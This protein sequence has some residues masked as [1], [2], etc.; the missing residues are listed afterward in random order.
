MPSNIETLSDTSDYPKSHSLFC[1]SLDTDIPSR[2]EAIVES[3]VD[4]PARPLKGAIDSFLRSVAD[5]IA[6]KTQRKGKRDS[7][8][9]DF[10]NGTD[11]EWEGIDSDST[12]EEEE[13]GEEKEEVNHSIDSQIMS[14]LQR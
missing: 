9:A 7:E 13:E 11:D 6:L 3:V 14:L 8:G 1:H 4:Q 2:L 5:A 10:A 12:D